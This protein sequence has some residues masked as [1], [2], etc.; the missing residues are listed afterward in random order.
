MGRADKKKLNQYLQADIIVRRQKIPIE[1]GLSLRF[2]RGKEGLE[3][4]VILRG[5]MWQ[6]DTVDVS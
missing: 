1:S 6:A 2:N 4:G 3:F 5:E